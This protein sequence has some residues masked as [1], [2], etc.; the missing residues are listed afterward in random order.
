MIKQADLEKGSDA[1]VCLND[2]VTSF[3]RVS[4]GEQFLQT[5]TLSNT[6]QTRWDE[7]YTL[8]FAGDHRMG[9]PSAVLFPATRP[10]RQGDLVVRFTAP[11]R[12]GRYRSSWQPRNPRGE[13]FGPVLT[14]DIEVVQL[15]TLD[16]AEFV[17][18]ISIPDGT[19]VESGQMIEKSW[20]VRNNGT[21]A[22]VPGYALVFVSHLQMDGPDSVVLPQA[23]PGE[24]V[25]VRVTLIA[26]EE[27]GLHRSSW[28]SRNANG[29]LFGDI[30]FA[31]IRVAEQ[32]DD[33]PRSNDARLD[34]HV[35]IPN[36]SQIAPG[37]TMHK[38]WAVR[39]TGTTTWEPGYAL[40][41]V[42][43]LQMDGP[44]S[45]PIPT[46]APQQVVQISL[47]LIA[48]H[49]PDK[50]IGRWRLRDADGKFFGPTLFVSIVVKP[51]IDTIDM[52]GYLQGDGRLYEMKHIFQTAAG[53]HVGQ[54]RIQTQ[55]EGRRFYIVKNEEWEE[56][57]YDD[58][59]IYR[60]T[61][62][63][64]GNGNFYSL[65]E[66]NR[67][68][69]PWIPRQMAPGHFFRR[70]PTVV[71]RRKRDCNVNFHLSGMQV[72]WIRL[73]EIH[74]EFRLPSADEGKQSGILVKDVV[75]LGAYVDKG[76]R[77]ASQPFERY[78]YA[79]GLGMVMWEGID[80]EHRGRSYLVEL[81]KP[82][83]RPDNQRESLPCLEYLLRGQS[84]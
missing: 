66:E 64:P 46:A 18:D 36:G 59:H 1:A 3:R 58:D 81:H 69:S 42:G 43:G 14:A 70:S 37:E 71:S 26:P 9:A 12:P 40:G 4:A 45:I 5:W 35:T 29:Q 75:E 79:K 54:Q 76:G 61:D 38:T 39:N 30:L 19:L 52:L 47:D 49:T 16:S 6:G 13:N 21:S 72:T 51:E 56:L 83:A 57:W 60:G 32:D 17:A 44:N 55:T 23:L 33:V 74:S 22:W 41:F 68:G 8:S 20:R 2:S 62:T 63:S 34:S 7:G 48:P 80:V 15:G 11:A 67:Y 28:R 77:P 24:E 53:L 65:M 78:Y 31:E 50:C 84:N 73:E 10:G 25:E 27:S 82:G